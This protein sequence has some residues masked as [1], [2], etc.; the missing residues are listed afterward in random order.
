MALKVLNS[1]FAYNT[2]NKSGSGIAAADQTSVSVSGSR[3][4]H[5]N[6]S[7]GS[8]IYAGSQSSVIVTDSAFS[9]NSGNVGASINVQ[10]NS[11]LEV[12][13]STFTENK[14]IYWKA[15]AGL[16]G[17]IAAGYQTLLYVTSCIFTG[18]KA[19]QG[20]ALNIQENVS[21]FITNSTFKYN[22]ADAGGVILATNRVSEVVLQ[23]DTSTFLSNNARL[24]IIHFGQNV[25]A[26][27]TNCSFVQNKV[28]K[29]SVVLATDNTHVTMRKCTLMWNVAEQGS[30]LYIFNSQIK[31]FKTSLSHHYSNIIYMKES[32]L[33]IDTCTFLDNSLKD[34][35]LI[36]IY[37]RI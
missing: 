30:C 35:S 31:L 4:M 23:I 27:L 3:F 17:G 12:Q 14:A 5:N 36:Q 25:H 34:A 16:G 9:H 28:K 26:S 33:D 1:T 7:A 6:A 10:N 15:R 2:A 13:N 37:V 18:N 20:G 22:D 8:G 21:I 19:Y 11:R 32:D 29:G 24:G